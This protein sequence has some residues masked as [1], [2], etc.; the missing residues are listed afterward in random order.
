M[1]DIARRLTSTSFVVICGIGSGGFFTLQSGIV[2]QILGLNRLQ[3]GIGF[4]EIAG[5]FGFLAGPISAGALL[6]AFG[7]PDNGPGPYRPA[8]VRWRLTITPQRIGAD[9]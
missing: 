3:R 9:G 7:G 4:L 1:D 6:D 8:I 2:S 5:S